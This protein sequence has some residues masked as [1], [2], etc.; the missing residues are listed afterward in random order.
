MTDDM[1]RQKYNKCE[2]NIAS[3]S[4]LLSRCGQVNYGG[5]WPDKIEVATSLAAFWTHLK[6][7][8]NYHTS[9]L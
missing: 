2:K 9:K 3:S 1:C 6:G 5:K 7:T 4:S 8:N